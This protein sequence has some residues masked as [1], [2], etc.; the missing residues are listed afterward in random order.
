MRT[1]DV[2]TPL[3]SNISTR[4]RAISLE[5]Y[6][7]AAHLHWGVNVVQKWLQH[8]V[9]TLP[10]LDITSNEAALDDSPEVVNPNPQS[11]VENDV[12]PPVKEVT[13]R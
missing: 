5:A 9:R 8:L 12:A 7:G 13:P 1:V 11:P 3:Q 2:S 4:L 10:H 6:I